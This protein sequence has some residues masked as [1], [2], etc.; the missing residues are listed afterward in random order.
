MI[1]AYLIFLLDRRK[2]QRAFIAAT[3]QRVQERTTLLRQIRNL[4][5]WDDPIVFSGGTIA[6]TGLRV[7]TVIDKQDNAHSFDGDTVA[8]ARDALI[9]YLQGERRAG[10]KAA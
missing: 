1:P 8:G 7:F 2:R 10:D 6:R 5:L 3:W 4:T 9:A